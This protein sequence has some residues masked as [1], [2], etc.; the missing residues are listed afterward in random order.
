MTEVCIITIGGGA[1]ERAGERERESR[2]EGERGR[3]GERE[4]E[5]RGGDHEMWLRAFFSKMLVN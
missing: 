5:E 1:G 2:R 3:E 4:R